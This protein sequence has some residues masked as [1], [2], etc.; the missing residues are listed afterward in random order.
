[1]NK[2]QKW[3]VILAILFAVLFILWL[4][5]PGWRIAKI[6]GFIANVLLFLSIFISYRAEKK[7]KDNPNK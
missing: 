2:R 1:M 6:L 7:K 3:Q 4:F 5:E